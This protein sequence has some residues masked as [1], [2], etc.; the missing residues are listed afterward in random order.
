MIKKLFLN[1]GLLLLCLSLVA[2]GQKS[3]SAG[4]DNSSKS[5]TSSFASGAESSLKENV[6]TTSPSVEN[7][8]ASKQEDEDVQNN[9]QQEGKQDTEP[10]VTEKEYYD[11]I[12]EAWQQQKDYIDSID[13]PEVKQSA[14][15]A[16]SA[17]ILKSNELLLAHPED[18][19]AIDVSLKKVLAGE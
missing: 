3:N 13:D 18:S 8:V 14:Q 12:K 9:I 2:C 16:Q 6:K 17:A 10:E 11:L 5:S 1:L 7:P 19:N 15:T 4:E